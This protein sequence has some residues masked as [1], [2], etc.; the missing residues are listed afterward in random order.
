MLGPTEDYDA[1]N[2]SELSAALSS[3]RG[4]SHLQC[5]AMLDHPDRI[6]M[7]MPRPSRGSDKITRQT[8]FCRRQPP[9]TDPLLWQ[10]MDKT[11]P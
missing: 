11:S 10:V 7:N 5:T 3:T 4:L 2:D 8:A 9:P 1:I 6:I